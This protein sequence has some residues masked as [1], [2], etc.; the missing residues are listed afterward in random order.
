MQR[1]EKFG[2]GLSI[3][4]LYLCREAFS[5][6]E[7]PDYPFEQMTRSQTPVVT[8]MLAILTAH[9]GLLSSSA[10]RLSTFHYGLHH[11]FI[12]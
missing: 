12:L 6:P 11:S 4:Y 2:F 10:C 5:P 1:L 9:Q 8:P 3:F 7:F